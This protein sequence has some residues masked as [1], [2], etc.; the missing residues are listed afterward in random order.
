MIVRIAMVAV[1]FLAGLSGCGGPGRDTAAAGSAGKLKV[2]ATVGMI[3]DL[4]ARIGGE[5]IDITTLMGAGTDPHLYK[6]NEHD[7]RQLDQ[8]D[9]IFYNGLNLEGKMQ[10]LFI[11]MA[12]RKKRVYAVSEY[13]DEKLLREPP[14]F[15]GHHDPHIWF[16]VSLWMKAAERIRDGLSDAAPQHAESFKANAAALLKELNELHD[17]TGKELA[18]IPKERRVL[19][20]AHDAFGYFGRAYDIE[21]HGIQGISTEDQA[22]VAA[23]NQLVDLIVKRGVK[24][25]FVE[26]SVPK[27]NI[28]ALVEG[29]KS[30]G[31][32][33]IIGGELFSDAM[34]EKGT[35]DGTYI[36]MV[37]HNVNTIVKAL[38]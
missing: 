1:L 36:G 2:A 8:S 9:V 21:V 26:S 33:I 30:R 22:S 4:A 20:T 7:I 35:P 29:C 28:E 12:N 6:A 17:W 37:K 31:H 11:K 19:I 38:K 25:V 23:V 3:G 16:D 24:A 5:R 15:N 10:D 27:K 34:G 13:I 14:E 18:Q 32:T